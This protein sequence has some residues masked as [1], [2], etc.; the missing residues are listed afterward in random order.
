VLLCLHVLAHAETVHVLDT[1][2]FSPQPNHT[3]TNQLDVFASY[4]ARQSKLSPV[5]HLR[6]LSVLETDFRP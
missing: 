3:L 4:P 6:P 5:L 1:M 2:D